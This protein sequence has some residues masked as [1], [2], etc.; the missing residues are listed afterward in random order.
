M[1]SALLPNVRPIPWRSYLVE[2]PDLPVDG[3][4][5]HSVAV[6]VKQDSLLFGVASQRRAQLLHLVDSGVQALLVARL[7]NE[8]YEKI[9][10]VP[11]VKINT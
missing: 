4:P 2:H 8:T 10:R 9:V 3:G 1:A 5:R 7:R 6:V 11:H